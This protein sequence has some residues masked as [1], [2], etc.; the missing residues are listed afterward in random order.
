MLQ[1]QTVRDLRAAIKPQLARPTPVMYLPP[2]FR[3]EM[4][5]L[6]PESAK[7]KNGD[8]KKK[9]SGALVEVE[10]VNDGFAD[11][12]GDN[13]NMIGATRRQKAAAKNRQMAVAD[14]KSN[15]KLMAVLEDIPLA[16]A[17]SGEAGQSNSEVEQTQPQ[18]EEKPLSRAERRK[19][20]KEEILLAGEG[21]GFKGYRRRMW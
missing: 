13:D 2:Q 7:E 5:G 21:E 6:A 11:G 17:D 9:E 8:H 12:T 1:Q 15:Q 18:Q 16:D 20:I 4:L 10:L 19:K 3:D 14:A